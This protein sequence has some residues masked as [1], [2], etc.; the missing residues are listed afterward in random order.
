MGGTLT[1]IEIEE[2]LY[3]TLEKSEH[4]IEEAID[5]YLGEIEAQACQD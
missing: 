5:P 3:E 1:V 2:N 4:T